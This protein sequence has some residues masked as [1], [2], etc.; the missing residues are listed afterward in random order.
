MQ[1]TFEATR[2]MA[3]DHDNAIDVPSF[4]IEYAG[5]FLLYI[6]FLV[7]YR[8]ELL[9]AQVFW[10]GVTLYTAGY[11]VFALGYFLQWSDGM[12]TKLGSL[13]LETAGSALFTLGSVFL[14]VVAE[15][16]WTEGVCIGKD[17]HG[18][19]QGGAQ[20]TWATWACDVFI[21]TPR[22]WHGCILFLIGS[23]C[24]LGGCVLQQ[25]ADVEDS[26]LI[27]TLFQLG[28]FTFVI[29]R[30]FF[31]IDA[32]TAIKQGKEFRYGGNATYMT[33][34]AAYILICLRLFRFMK[35]AHLR[36]LDKT[37][38]NQP[39]D[40]ALPPLP[41]GPWRRKAMR[42]ADGEWGTVSRKKGA[43][44]FTLRAKLLQPDNTYKLR[45]ATFL[46]HE[47][48]RNEDGVFRP[49]R[50]AGGM[51][52][53]N[54]HILNMAQFFDSI[55]FGGN[56]FINASDLHRVVTTL[57]DHAT[58]ED[59]ESVVLGLDLDA[60]HCTG[61]VLAIDFPEFLM[62]CS[63]AL[64]GDCDKELDLAWSALD[65]DRSGD[66]DTQELLNIMRGIG[67][68]NVEDDAARLGITAT[69]NVKE[70]AAEFIRHEGLNG[71]FDKQSFLELMQHGSRPHA[72]MPRLARSASRLVP[73][74][75]QTSLRF[76]APDFDVNAPSHRSSVDVGDTSKLLIKGDTQL[77]MTGP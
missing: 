17:S 67:L 35:E 38:A 70:T 43:Q 16:P 6:G 20:R 3:N 55:D 25:V 26:D 57:G 19:G 50:C 66:C 42:N 46:A 21:G 15:P 29:G 62:L 45:T 47:T 14:V 54:R 18:E 37:S 13:P 41:G 30:L 48:F 59:M 5:M 39:E 58:L 76:S 51:S 4:A 61:G 72:G 74:M 7:I 27:G 10:G 32:M 2:I 49:G 9:M 44:C 33:N 22:V 77:Y 12:S 60:G 52:L 34:T 31:V 73:A 11:G 68:D 75:S 40:T 23:L 53:S 28:I 8:N 71:R 36:V 1:T 65:P 64:T 63:T 24:F 69:A 56:G